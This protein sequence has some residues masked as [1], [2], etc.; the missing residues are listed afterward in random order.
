LIEGVTIGGIDQVKEF[1]QR[2]TL[3]MRRRQIVFSQ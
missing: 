3:R 1:A 2:H